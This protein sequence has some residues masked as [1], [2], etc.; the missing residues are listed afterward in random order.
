MEA[1]NSPMSRHEKLLG[2]LSRAQKMAKKKRF[3]KKNKA[4]EAAPTNSGEEWLDPQLVEEI[5]E[6]YFASRD[7]EE[8]LEAIR[9][10][11]ATGQEALFL[12]LETYLRGNGIRLDVVRNLRVADIMAATPTYTQC[13]FCLASALLH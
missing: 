10:G 1:E 4:R 2:S 6:D 9:Q 11:Q 5:R 8:N 12:A 3:T 7:R 13:P